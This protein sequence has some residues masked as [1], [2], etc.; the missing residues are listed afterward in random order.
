VAS[1]VFNAPRVSIATTPF[2]RF[3]APPMAERA[4]YALIAVIV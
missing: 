3:A 1:Q 4:P 2:R